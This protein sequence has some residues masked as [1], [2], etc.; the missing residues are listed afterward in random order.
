MQI[1]IIKFRGNACF[2]SEWAGF[3]KIKPINIIIGRNNTGKSQ[4]LDFVQLLCT[5]VRGSI[6]CEL[7][8]VGKLSESEL[9]SVFL[10][11]NSGR[12]LSG[13]HWFDHGINFVEHIFLWDLIRNQSPSSIRSSN[14]SDPAEPVTRE[15]AAFISGLLGSASTPLEGRE[16][17]RLLADRDIQPEPASTTLSLDPNGRGATNIIKRHIISSNSELPRDRIQIELRDALNSIFGEDGHFSEIQAQEHEDRGCWEIYL[18]EAKKGLIPLSKSGSGLKTVILVLLHLLVLPKINGKPSSDFIFTFE[19]L[20][21]NLHPALLRRLLGY[22]DRFALENST[23]IFLTTHSNV[24]LD[25][26]GTSDHAQII[27]VTHDGTTA[28]TTTIDTHFKKLGVVSELGA[29]PSD[30]LQTNGIV[31]VEGPSDAI[32]INKWIELVSD[33]KFIEG[34][35]YLCAFYGGSLLARTQFSDPDQATDNL[36]NLFLANPNVAIICDSDKK[37][38][39]GR[40]KPRVLRI[41][42]EIGKIPGGLVWV[43]YP[44]EIENYLSG[45]IIAKA[46]AMQKQPRSPDAYE[47]FF[48]AETANGASY[49][50]KVLG[51]TSI[52]K[53]AFALRC[54]ENMTIAEMESRFDWKSRME[55]LFFAISRWNS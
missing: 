44:K 32:Y 53:I 1:D 50:E 47:N 18:G 8:C 26:F 48:P 33:G 27:H 7:T 24:A 52:D 4:L 34:R 41:R 42:D 2:V 31:W 25:L 55:S 38:S 11:N 43:T 54:R 23:A 14:G 3:D 22:I 17:F 20:E 6:P 29:K 36:V 40:L 51:K 21:N 45:N 15:R 9:R 16:F 35:D 39:N 30:I 5:G 37:S 49:A 13:N 10:Q 12:E 46:Q 28:R 19:E